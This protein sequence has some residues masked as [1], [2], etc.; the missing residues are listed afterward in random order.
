MTNVG[1]MQSANKSAMQNGRFTDCITRVWNDQHAGKAMS[2]M[3]LVNGRRIGPSPCPY[4]DKWMV[5]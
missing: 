2:E 3:V 4:G 5:W 1:V